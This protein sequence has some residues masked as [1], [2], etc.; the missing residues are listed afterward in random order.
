[1][2]SIAVNH[3]ALGKVKINLDPE[4]VELFKNQT[5]FL[6]REKGREVPTYLMVVLKNGKFMNASRW[7][8][9]QH[10]LLKRGRKRVMF[11]DKNSFNLS[12]A[13]LVQF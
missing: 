4:D 12:K 1:M 13:N 9:K 2:K 3:R 5:V 6:K 10:K 11:N 8:L 7:L